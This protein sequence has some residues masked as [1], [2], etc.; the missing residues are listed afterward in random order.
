MKI[1]PQGAGVELS[2]VAVAL[3]VIMFVVM[4]IQRPDAGCSWPVEV[5]SPLV[6]SRSMDREHLATDQASADRIARRFMLSTDD[7][8]QAQTRF[9]E[10]QATLVDEIAAR[11]GLSPAQVRANRVDAA[12]AQ[13]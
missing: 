2:M 10:C 3:M 8:E 4:W 1:T 12:P 11:H 6:L 9:I 5:S 7:R 13:R